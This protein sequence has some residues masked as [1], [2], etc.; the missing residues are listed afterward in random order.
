M[1]PFWS[2]L[3]SILIEAAAARKQQDESQSIPPHYF[4]KLLFTN[5]LLM[6]R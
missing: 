3:S 1:I 4:S 6:G 5:C 2:Q